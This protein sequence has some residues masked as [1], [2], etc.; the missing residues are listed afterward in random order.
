[1][2]IDEKELRAC[3]MKQPR[4]AKILVVNVEGDAQEVAGVGKGGATWA[5]VAR[6]IMA[7]VPHM[8]Q[9]Y[10][11][12]GVLLR[13]VNAEQA[14]ELPVAVAPPPH[15]GTHAG[16][17]TAGL[18]TDPETA[19]FIHVSNLIAE[20]YR[21]ATVTAFDRLASLAESAAERAQAT[22][23]RLEIAEAN[24]R[25]ERTERAEDLFEEAE[26]MR[27]AAERGDKQGA[28]NIL[29]EFLSNV[30]A[31]SAAKSANGAKS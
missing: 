4:P 16:Y 10:D 1:M 12:A 24:Y 2:A 6:N 15:G 9:L 13:A 22:E 7:L 8:V 5:G 28:R 21:F 30:A 20:A 14:V 11:A 17:S 29:E 27:E 25:R 19:R 18:P 3:L 31:G 23:Q 26:A